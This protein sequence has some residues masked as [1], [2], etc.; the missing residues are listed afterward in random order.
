MLKEG[1]GRWPQYLL[2]RWVVTKRMSRP[3]WTKSWSQLP[4]FISCGLR[5]QTKKYLCVCWSVI[6]TTLMMCVNIPLLEQCLCL[7]EIS[8]RWR[9]TV[10]TLRRA[11]RTLQHNIS[12]FSTAP[13]PPTFRLP[14]WQWRLSAGNTEELK[15]MM[16]TWDFSFSLSLLFL[17]K[18]CSSS[19]QWE[20]WREIFLHASIY[21]SFQ[22]SKFDWELEIATI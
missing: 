4:S 13:T 20:R 1:G 19:L 17:S 12:Q 8:P 11:L 15:V 2:L 22:L 7:W 21:R 14:R 5:S 10:R 18:H 6:N 3:N 16:F 9:R